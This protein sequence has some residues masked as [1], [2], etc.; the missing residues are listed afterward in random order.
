[1]QVYSRGALFT[2]AAVRP[3]ANSSFPAPCHIP[4]NLN[5]TILAQ[6]AKIRVIGSRPD[7]LI[8]DHRILDAKIVQ[9]SA[10]TDISRDIL[11]MAVVERHHGSGK[12]GLGF[13]QGFGLK[14]G[15]IA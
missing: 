5:F 14:R 13:I 7:Q 6:T 10:F 11:K 4:A 3:D 9:S 8:T 12:V 2:P 1:R 15:A